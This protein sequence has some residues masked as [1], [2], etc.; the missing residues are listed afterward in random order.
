MRSTYV[1]SRAGSLSRLLVLVSR[2]YLCLSIAPPHYRHVLR[3]KKTVKM[4]ASRLLSTLSIVIAGA[5]SVSGAPV[6]LYSRAVQDHQIHT[7]A[8]FRADPVNFEPQHVSRL[9]FAYHSDTH[10]T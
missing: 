9:P 2:K 7:D 8:V 3:L 5:L 10:L 4:L 6:D 1:F